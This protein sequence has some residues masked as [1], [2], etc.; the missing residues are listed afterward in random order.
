M[1]GLKL[2]GIDPLCGAAGCG[3][4]DVGVVGEACAGYGSVFLSCDVLVSDEIA[5]ECREG[6]YCGGD[7]GGEIFRRY[8]YKCRR[9]FRALARV[10]LEKRLQ[11][12][13]EIGE[14]LARTGFG[15]SCPDRNQRPAT[16]SIS[17]I[18][19]T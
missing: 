11:D 5:A 7:L 16:L 18:L 3:D 13:E 8:E 19:H 14:S 2:V 10:I 6:F 9:L 1:F 4:Y 15:A 12:R 17:S